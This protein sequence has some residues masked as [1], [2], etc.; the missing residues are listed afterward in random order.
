MGLHARPAA[1]SRERAKRLAIQIH[2]HKWG[3]A[4]P[5][6]HP[7]TSEATRCT[8][9]CKFAAAACAATA[10]DATKKSPFGMPVT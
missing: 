7:E 4:Q 2:A 6:V 1:R 9:G 8:A 5:V 3:A 10:N